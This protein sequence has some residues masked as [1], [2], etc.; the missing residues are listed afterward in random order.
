MFQRCNLPAMIQG[1]L[2]TSMNFNI[3]SLV[4]ENPAVFL[5]EICAKIVQ[6]TGITVSGST[7]CKVNVLHRNG[8]TRKKLV[9]VAIQRSTDHRGAL[10]PTF[11]NIP[12]T[13]WMWLDETGSDRRDQLRK[14]DYALDYHLFASDFMLVHGT[15]I[16]AI[17]GNVIR[18][19]GG[20]WVISGFYRFWQIYR[21]HQRRFNS[22]YMQPFPDKHSILI[23]DNCSIHHGAEVKKP[24]LKMQAFYSFFFTT[25]QSRL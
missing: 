5:H 22:Y 8:F 23:M 7:V 16:S 3:I 10:L 25:L 12:V 19:C 24:L 4:Y 20:L 11:C 21:L 13:S 1:R 15:R 18:W 9:K 6:A 14:F 17:V 2:I